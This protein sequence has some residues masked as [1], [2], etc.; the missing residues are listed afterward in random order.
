LTAL[1]KETGQL[2]ADAKIDQKDESALT[3]ARTEQLR[4]PKHAVLPPYFWSAFSF[5]G[6]WR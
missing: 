5:S 4:N 1:E 6:D 2:R 3:R